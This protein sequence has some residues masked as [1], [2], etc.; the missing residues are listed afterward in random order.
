MSFR[1]IALAVVAGLLLG[2]ISFAR[3]A[4][5]DGRAEAHADH[6]PRHGGQLGMV[7]DHHVE[8]DEAARSRSG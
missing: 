6:E 5:V 4:H 1:R 3:Y 7:G 2:V 8:L